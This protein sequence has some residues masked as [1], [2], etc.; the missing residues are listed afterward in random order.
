[1]KVLTISRLAHAMVLMDFDGTFVLADPWFAK[2]PAR[3]GGPSSLGVNGLPKLSLVLVS[4][5][6]VGQADWKSLAAYP[7]K[8][9]LVA[10][11]PNQMKAANKSGFGFFAAMDKPWE[12]H[13]T[14][15][16]SLLTG[17]GLPQGE[18]VTAVLQ[19]AGFTVYWGGSS[20]FDPRIAEMLQH[21][22]RPDVAFLPVTKSS[23]GLLSSKCGMAPEEAA[24]ICGVLNPK[25]AIPIGEGAASLNAQKFAA[26]CAVFAPETKVK[27]LSAG[28]VYQHKK[29]R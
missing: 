25:V 13:K 18:Q 12:G 4:G 7:D 1:M 24:G 15:P 20:L 6:G 9:L 29:A 19:C 28:A 10:G 8:S 5:S 26:A 27:V 23:G 17:P 14:G 2:K 16:L 11:P 3:L 22:D 21:T